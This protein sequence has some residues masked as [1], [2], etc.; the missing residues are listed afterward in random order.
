MSD[1]RRILE[2][3]RPPR[4][5]GQRLVSSHGYRLIVSEDECDL[6]RFEV[7]LGKQAQPVRP[8]ICPRLP[9]CSA[10]HWAN[11]AGRRCSTSLGSSSHRW[12]PP[13]CMK[14]RLSAVEAAAEVELALGRPDRALRYQLDLSDAHPFR[15]RRTTVV[16]S[17][18]G[19]AHTPRERPRLAGRGSVEIRRPGL[20]DNRLQRAALPWQSTACPCGGTS[21]TSRGIP[22]LTEPHASATRRRRGPLAGA[23]ILLSA[24]DSRALLSLARGS[25][26]R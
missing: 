12:L 10:G 7:L 9:G 21:A 22:H 26:R 3:D 1:L 25:A 16:A 19:G 24:G 11:G 4:A 5:S 13:D 18:L 15:E 23:A 14:A 8:V 6:M 2:P 20:P 17:K